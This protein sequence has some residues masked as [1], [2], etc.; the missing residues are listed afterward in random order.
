MLDGRAIG[1]SFRTENTGDRER[2]FR[3][4]QRHQFFRGS[5]FGHRLIDIKGPKPVTD[6]PQAIFLRL[7]TFVTSYLDLRTQIG[8]LTNAEDL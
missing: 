6:F 4:H 5:G 7:V 3:R 8:H 1:I 2:N